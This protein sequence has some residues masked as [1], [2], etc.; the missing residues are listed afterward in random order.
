[1]KAKPGNVT[2]FTAATLPGGPHV[3]ARHARRQREA[4]LGGLITLY[5]VCRFFDSLCEIEIRIYFG[6]W[7]MSS[8]VPQKLASKLKHI[9]TV[10][11]EYSEAEMAKAVEVSEKS[12]GQ[13]ER[14]ERV[15]SLIVVMRYARSIGLQME[16][17]V[18][19][20]LEIRPNTG[21]W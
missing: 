18:D 19:D 13:F 17:L 9:R 12:V 1:V 7:R 14:G 4:S 3:W 20:A 10:E 8:Q 5:Y 21:K 15:P 6:V 11:L 16:K 2:D